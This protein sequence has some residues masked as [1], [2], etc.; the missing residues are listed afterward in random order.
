M[1]NKPK[2]DLFST[3]CTTVRLKIVRIYAPRT[4]TKALRRRRY[5]VTGW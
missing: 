2:Y 4:R 3:I 5:T 1:H